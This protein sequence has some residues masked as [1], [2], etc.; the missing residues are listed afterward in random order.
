MT[1]RDALTF[2]GAITSTVAL[3]FGSIGAW[4]ALMDRPW[5]KLRFRVSTSKSAKV[6]AVIDVANHGRRRA[7]VFPPVAECVSA[8]GKRVTHTA[9]EVWEE[10]HGW[11]PLQGAG[12]TDVPLAIDERTSR[13]FLIYLQ[14]QETVLWVYVTDMLNKT[15]YRGRLTSR[16]LLVE[17]R[18]ANQ[19]ARA[20]N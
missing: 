18:T 16:M 14:P 1:L 7:L 9:E 19:S 8:K 20:S 5:L 12:H 3:V 15:K 2:Y 10:G 17:R 6:T 4:N 11:E 13:S